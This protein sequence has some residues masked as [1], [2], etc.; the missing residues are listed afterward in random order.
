M[1][2]K[3]RKQK[4]EFLKERIREDPKLERITIERQEHRIVLVTDRRLIISEKELIATII[5]A[6]TYM[7]PFFVCERVVEEIPRVFSRRGK[8]WML[9][10]TRIIVKTSGKK[11]NWLVIIKSKK[12]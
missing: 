2:T 7:S 6:V 10:K 8:K 9:G 4:F 3:K 5:E 11:K 12:S 1:K